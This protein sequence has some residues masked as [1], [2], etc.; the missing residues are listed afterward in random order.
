MKLLSPRYGSALRIGALVTVIGVASITTQSQKESS[1]KWAPQF[2]RD[3]A[4][5]LFENEHVIIWEQVG[6]PKEAF[7]HKHIRD[8]V[9]ISIEPGGGIDVLNPDGSKGGMS[10]LTQTIYTKSPVAITYAKAG[11]GPHAEVMRDP[12]KPGRS[13]V[14]EIKGT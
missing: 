3:G 9:G 8:I 4:T 14:I 5:K 7:M 11:I 2:P 10:P 1:Q 13:I 12:N 6:R